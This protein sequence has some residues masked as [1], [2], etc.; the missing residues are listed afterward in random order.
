MRRT[1]LAAFALLSCSSGAN[2]VRSASS[3][4]DCTEA[5]AVDAAAAADSPDETNAPAEASRGRFNI[6]GDAA[7]VQ[8]PTDNGDVCPVAV[9]DDVVL[10]C[11]ASDP[12]PY[13]T[14]LGPSGPAVGQCPKT[15]DFNKD[16]CA[17]CGPIEPAAAARLDAGLETS[18][19]YIVRSGCSP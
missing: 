7:I 19:C 8:I 13:D 4:A 6:L 1:I 17:A 18:C 5:G 2:P 9:T 3:C 10:A 12:A 11:F 14:Y 15:A 16:Q